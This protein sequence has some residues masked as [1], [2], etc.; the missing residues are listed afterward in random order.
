MLRKLLVTN[1][2]QFMT[3][4]TSRH[5]FLSREM[6]EELDAQDPFAQPE[7]KSQS[8][9][10]VIASCFDSEK[11]NKEKNSANIL[12]LSSDDALLPDSK[13]NIFK[14]PP[15]QHGLYHT[16]SIVNCIQYNAE[17][18]K[19]I[20]L[21]DIIPRTGQQLELEKIFSN[22]NSVI[23]KHQIKVVLNL[24]HG[25]EVGFTRCASKAECLSRYLIAQLQ[26]HLKDQI[27][28]ITPLNPMRR[29]ST[30]A[31]QLKKDATVKITA[32]ELKHAGVEVNMKPSNMMQITFHYGSTK[33]TQIQ[34]F[35]VN[36][37]NNIAANKPT[38]LSASSRNMAIVGLV[39]LAGF[40]ALSLFGASRASRSVA[41]LP[42]V[43][44]TSRSI[45]HKH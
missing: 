21:P 13:Q 4:L 27:E 9:A 11:E 6:A 32:E 5:Q 23:E 37:K 31:I 22:I 7:K 34:Q 39:S 29:G 17:R 30:I 10:T 14:L 35:V 33:F 12:M 36:L 44:M 2:D 45:S 19:M 1:P 40:A 20:I 42:K 24:A 15:D 25:V 16:E 8:L 43:G 38:F 3:E 26:H 28:V 41:E 18:L